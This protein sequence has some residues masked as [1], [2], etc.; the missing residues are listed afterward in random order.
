MEP[1]FLVVT[2]L[3]AGAVQSLK[4]EA[5]ASV[6]AS[7]ARL[8][9]VV[10][11]QLGENSV[12]V[13]VLHKYEQTPEAWVAPL[14]AELAEAGADSDPEVVA[15]AQE[16]MALLDTPGTRAGKYVINVSGSQGVQIGDGNTQ[17]NTFGP[18]SSHR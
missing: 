3:R 10:R 12:S 9:Q 16:L 11:K 15:A 5:R 14:Q 8:R 4:D 6:K 7:Y 1:V 17:V 2:A 13:S 18:P